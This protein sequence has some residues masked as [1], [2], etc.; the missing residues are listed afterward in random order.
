MNN[1]LFQKAIPFVLL[2]LVLSITKP[3]AANSSTCSTTVPYSWSV[4]RGEW[5]G[6]DS[7]TVENDGGDGP[8]TNSVAKTSNFSGEFKIKRNFTPPGDKWVLAPGE[9]I[10]NT[11]NFTCQAD[12]G[13]GYINSMDGATDS[14]FVGGS[15]ADVKASV[16][17]LDMPAFSNVSFYGPMDLNIWE[18]K[19]STPSSVSDG[20]VIP[21]SGMLYIET[22]F[23]Y[24]KRLF[25]MTVWGY[26]GMREGIDAQEKNITYYKPN[27]TTCDDGNPNTGPDTCQDGVCTGPTLVELHSFTATA[28][29]NSVLIEWKTDME[30]DNAGFNIWRSES[31]TGEYTKIN[32]SLIPAEGSEYQYSFTDDTA[33]KGKTYYY[34]LEDIDLNGTATFHG[35]V[36]T[37]R[38]HKGLLPAIQLLLGH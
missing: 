20:Q 12:L 27:G 13:S 18:K 19:A 22:A 3:L 5:M 17:C 7:L 33:V 31:E 23:P 9:V 4:V 29:E 35:P 37:K 6:S 15:Y 32:D 28:L 38:T 25:L 21:F 10:P 1:R 30:L 26:I 8:A 24:F 16:T 34:K 11:T 14:L 2:F 36:S